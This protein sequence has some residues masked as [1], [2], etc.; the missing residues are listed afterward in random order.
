MSPLNRPQST[1]TP[2]ASADRSRTDRVLS[3][4]TFIAAGS[5]T[6]L[7]SLAGC[8]AVA[9]FLA[10][11]ALQEV[12]VFNGADESVS[13]TIEV[14]DPDGETVLEE[15][16][17]LDAE[18]EDDGSDENTEATAQYDD[19]WT[20]AGDYEVTVALDDPL[21]EGTDD[22]SDESGN[23]TNETNE[24]DSTPVEE[25]ANESDDGESTPVE[26]GGGETDD[27]NETDGNET[28][29]DDPSQSGPSK[30]DTVSID[31]TDEQS[32]VIGIAQEEPA[33]L[34]S[35]HVIEDFSDLEDEF[36]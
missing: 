13:G 24:S 7:A 2:S 25:L 11:M 18:P 8:S 34:I 1:A 12:N 15:T 22:S 29:S 32:L 9:D 36:E 14:V 5:A 16:F 17:D 20:D 19:V 23:E 3:R 10:D 30:T 28:D 4:R 27:A 21:E 6:A 33:D 35:Y 31:D 26:N